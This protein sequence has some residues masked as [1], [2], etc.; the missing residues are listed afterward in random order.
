MDVRVGVPWHVDEPDRVYF[1]TVIGVRNAGR[2]L[3]VNLDTGGESSSEK[4]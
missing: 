1:G 2:C 4:V 3:R